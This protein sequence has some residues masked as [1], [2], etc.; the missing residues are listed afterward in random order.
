[1]DSASSTTGVGKIRWLQNAVTRLSALIIKLH[2]S[3]GDNVCFECEG[4]VSGGEIIHL[5]LDQ[6][7]VRVRV[8]VCV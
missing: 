7:E 6:C 3:C 8:C 1:M 4:V 2:F 5:K